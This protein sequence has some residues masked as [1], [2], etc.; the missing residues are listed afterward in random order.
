MQVCIETSAI[1]G[2]MLAVAVK[3]D[4]ILF[5]DD[6]LHVTPPTTVREAVTMAVDVRVRGS[7]NPAAS[8]LDVLRSGKRYGSVLAITDEEENRTVPVDWDSHGEVPGGAHAVH[9]QANFAD[10]FTQYAR[11]V[12]PGVQPTFVSFLSNIDRP[13]R[14]TPQLEAHGIRVPVFKLHAARPDLR[15]LDGIFAAMATA[16][17]D[18]FA[19]AVRERAAMVEARR[20]APTEAA[21]GMA[22]LAVT[23]D[24]QAGFVMVEN[25]VPA[26]R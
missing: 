17:G 22:E 4:I 18:V 15:R 23:E 8:M 21:A 10:V 9:R 12:A 5:A 14:M 16:G 11:T 26:E 24:G 7:T 19:D 25:D 13:G 20:A 6:V 2:C 1:V 3:A